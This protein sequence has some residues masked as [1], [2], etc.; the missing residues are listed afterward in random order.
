[1]FLGESWQK[2]LFLQFGGQDNWVSRI[3]LFGND[4]VRI[5]S[6]IRPKQWHHVCWRIS[7][8]SITLTVNN[9]EDLHLSLP[10]NPF[11]PD[12]APVGLM[13]HNPARLRKVEI[14]VYDPLACAKARLP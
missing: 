6:S 2:G 3:A 10:H 13:L 14:E 5:N 7:A 9:V 12:A 1:M 4:L 8:D 11:A